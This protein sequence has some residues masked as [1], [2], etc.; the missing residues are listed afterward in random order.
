MKKVNFTN[1]IGMD[2]F[3]WAKQRHPETQ[4]LSDFFAP[5]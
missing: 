4:K 3:A 2:S 5:D 1:S